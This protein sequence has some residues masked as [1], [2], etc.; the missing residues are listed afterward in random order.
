MSPIRCASDAFA[1]TRENK[2]IADAVETPKQ[3]VSE[4]LTAVRGSASSQGSVAILHSGQILHPAVQLSHV[5]WF[6]VS[7]FLLSRLSSIRM[8]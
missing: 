1:K 3:I 2:Q 5:I 6:L 7:Q 4:S 8:P